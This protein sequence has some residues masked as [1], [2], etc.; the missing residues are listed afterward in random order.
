MVLRIL[1][2]GFLR[3][4]HEGA[5][6]WH[7]LDDLAGFSPDVSLAVLGDWCGNVRNL[8]NLVSEISQAINAILLMINANL[9]NT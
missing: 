6:A 3:C 4:E 2:G 9:D 1:T 8:L 5:S 7:L